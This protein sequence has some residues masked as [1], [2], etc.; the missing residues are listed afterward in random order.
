MNV[1]LPD[2]LER[3]WEVMW[4]KGQELWGGL[5][6]ET[7]QEVEK[8]TGERITNYIC[9]KHRSN[10]FDNSSSRLST[11]SDSLH[12]FTGAATTSRLG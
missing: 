1:E 11:E 5:G 9:T 8:M 4:M 7:S 2:E 6:K 12:T 10:S 3:K